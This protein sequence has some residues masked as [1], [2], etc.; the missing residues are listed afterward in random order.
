MLRETAG[1]GLERSRES[2]PCREGCRCHFH[3]HTPHSPLQKAG[4]GGAR[5]GG[6][7]GRLQSMTELRRSAANTHTLPAAS[8]AVAVS[9]LG[10]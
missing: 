6:R 3:S 5:A 8:A 9:A 2:L 1:F 10:K 7:E 4:G